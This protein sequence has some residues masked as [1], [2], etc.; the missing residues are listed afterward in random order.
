MARSNPPLAPAPVELGVK[1][2]HDFRIKS[3]V[4]GRLGKAVEHLVA[5]T[6]I[7]SSRGVLNVSTALVDDEGVDLVFHRRGGTRTLAA[8]VKAR[9]SDSSTSQ[10]GH[11]SHD[12]RV[13][14]FRPRDDLYMLYVAVDVVEGHLD[15]AWLV[16]SLALA[17]VVKPN[18]RKRLRFAASMK[19][20]SRDQWSSYRLLPSALPSKILSEL[21]HLD[22]SGR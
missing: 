6:C 14:T 9:M 19:P 16:P 4:A 7:I 3:A 2:P 21:D 8:Q 10:R 15:M 20:G 1:Q 13:Q 17:Q 11:F 12:A 22:R 18:S 5:A